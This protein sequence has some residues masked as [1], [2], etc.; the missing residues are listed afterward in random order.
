MLNF[1]LLLCHV[2]SVLHHSRSS[3]DERADARCYIWMVS[4]KCLWDKSCDTPGQS[5]KW[6]KNNLIRMLVWCPGVLST[7]TTQ[8]LMTY[9]ILGL[10][11][12][13]RSLSFLPPRRLRTFSWSFV[14]T[15]S[16]ST[17]PCLVCLSLSRYDCWNPN[18]ITIQF[19]L[20]VQVLLPQKHNHLAAMVFSPTVEGSSVTS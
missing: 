5:F 20:Y 10:T 4:F 13:Q 8:N 11:R 12:T 18:L 19:Y 14:L 15:K 6:S 17:H 9:K 1:C 7:Q 16:I 3:I 2:L